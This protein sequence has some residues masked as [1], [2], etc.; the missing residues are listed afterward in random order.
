MS[1][2]TDGSTPLAWDDPLPEKIMNRWQY[3]KDSLRDLQH[4][5]IPRCYC[6]KEFCTTARPELHGFP[7]A[8]QDAIGASVYLKLWNEKKEVSVSFVCRSTDITPQTNEIYPLCESDS[9]VRKEVDILATKVNTSNDAVGLGVKR[10]EGF[11]NLSSLQHA[12]AALIVIVRKVS[13]AIM[14]D[15]KKKVMLCHIKEL[16]LLVPGV[17]MKQDST[18]DGEKE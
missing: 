13:I 6:P 15:G 11:S 10:F 4:V 12:I 18:K 3:W 16:I 7:D 8:S 2:A 5:S 1:K 14:K 17:V 9:E